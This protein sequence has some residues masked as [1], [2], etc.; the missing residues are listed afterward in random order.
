M[1][2]IIPT[3][4]FLIILIGLS[5]YSVYAQ[6]GFGQSITKDS[7]KKL[8][9]LSEDKNFSLDKRLLFVDILYAISISVEN[10]SLKNEALK[11]Y[12]KFNYR[13]KNWKLFNKYRQEHIQHTRKINDSASRAKTYDYSAASFIMQNK[14]DSAY[15]YYIKSIKIYKG[16]KDSLATGGILLN[17]AILEKNIHDYST[18][19]STSFE[20]LKY[21][22]FEDNR[23]TLQKVINRRKAS[24]YNNLG[25]IYNQFRDKENSIK[26]HTKAKELRATLKDKPLYLL[27]S[28]NN[29]GKVSCDNKDYETAITTYRIILSNDS[30]L[31]ANLTFKAVVLDNISYA[32]FKNG[33]DDNIEETFQEALS[34]REKEKDLNGIIINCIHLAEYYAHQKDTVTALNYARRAEKLSK[35]TSNYRD[36]LESLELMSSLYDTDEARKHFQIYISI[37][38]SLD[39]ASRKYK[40]KF[41]RVRFEIDELENSVSIV[42]GINKKTKTAIGILGT[43]LLIVFGFYFKSARNSKK[44]KQKLDES[45]SEIDLLKRSL[46]DLQKRSDTSSGDDSIIDEYHAFLVDKYNLNST[47]ALLEYWI[48]RTERYSNVEIATKLFKSINTIKDRKKRLIK[49]INEINGKGNA[50]RNFLIDLYGYELNEFIKKLPPN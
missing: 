36:Y 50:T 41:E 40:N 32:R 4:K 12:F 21:L 35:S 47:P 29:I 10:D 18:S 19:E 11:K 2:S 14:Q 43:I 34:I 49:K 26:Y 24:A 20:S 45:Y 16:L 9:I 25:I 5:F 38:D 28:L 22:S 7:I 42:K 33:A 48:L 37:R 27:H 23:D 13:K 15:Y 31:A 30:I 3:L 6:K 17:K 44:Q 46:I 1:V 39:L 8:S